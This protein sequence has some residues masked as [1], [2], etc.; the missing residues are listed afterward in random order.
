MARPRPSL[1]PAAA[2]LALADAEGRIAVRVSPNASGDAIA[3]PTNGGSALVIR[4]TV[5]PED[6]RANTAVI[7]LL[8]KALGRPASALEL[9]RGTSGRDKVI[10]ILP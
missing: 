9:V 1:P 4:T 2:I 6:G 10:R 8:A 7:R 3:L 5:V